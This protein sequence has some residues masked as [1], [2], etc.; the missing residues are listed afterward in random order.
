M[1]LG[2][3]GSFNY[4]W[5][6]NGVDLSNGGPISGAL[7]NTLTINP[8][9]PAHMGA[10][11]CVISTV[12]GTRRSNPAGLAVMPCSGDIN[13]DCARNGSDIAGFVDL[14]LTASGPCP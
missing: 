1:T 12:N 2:G 14:L 7:T 11:D 6:K 13:V 8:V 4:Q 10:Y 3:P 5:R 9:A